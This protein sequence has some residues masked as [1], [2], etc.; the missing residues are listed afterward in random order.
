MNTT[1]VVQQ[2]DDAPRGDAATEPSRRFE[3]TTVS[4]AQLAAEGSDSLKR[5]SSAWA[6]AVHCFAALVAGGCTA[7]LALLLITFDAE[8]TK[9]CLLSTVMSV[10]MNTTKRTAFELQMYYTLG[11]PPASP[12]PLNRGFGA[13]S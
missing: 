2:E 12:G 1:D 11:R 9:A 13:T 8:T 4:P 6:V 3:T 5:R 10:L 7:T